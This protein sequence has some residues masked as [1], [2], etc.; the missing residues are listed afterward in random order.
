MMQKKGEFIMLLLKIKN[1]Y[2]S[3]S[4]NFI[5]SFLTLVIALLPN[6]PSYLLLE[7]IILIQMLIFLFYLIPDIYLIGS[8]L[9]LII[10][11]LWLSAIF[12]DIFFIDLSRVF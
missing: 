8:N 4:F 1:I 2:I 3:D 10:Y 6:N 9:M 12:L 11:R 7:F 5:I